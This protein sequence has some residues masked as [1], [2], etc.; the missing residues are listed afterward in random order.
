[1]GQER[2]VGKARP[3]AEALAALAADGHVYPIVMVDGQLT[4][5]SAALPTAWSE[6]RLRTPAGMVTVGRGA[7]V[8]VK[9]FG[10]ADPALLETRDRIA[11][12]FELAPGSSGV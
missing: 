4:H 1:M 11:R 3:L 6:V 9:V 8:V 7:G 5:P 10:N 12:A 2:L